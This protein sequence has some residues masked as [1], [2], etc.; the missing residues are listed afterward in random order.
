MNVR[1]GEITKDEELFKA[2]ETA[3]QLSTDIA[4]NVQD[5]MYATTLNEVETGI[6]KLNEFSNKCW[7]LSAITIYTLIYN[8]NMYEQSGLV[9]SEYLAESKS[10]LGLDPRDISEQLSSA[11][12]FI[13]HR[14]ALVRNG[15]TPIGSSRKL[16]R[17]E[18]ALELCGDIDLVINHVINDSWRD[19]KAWYESY[20]KAPVLP[21]PTDVEKSVIRYESNKVYINDI[22]AVTISSQLPVADRERYENY[23]RQV[24]DAI[25]EGLE[26]AIIPCYDYKEKKHLERL[27]DKERAK[28]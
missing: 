11:R 19:F 15:W 13:S 14:E 5:L 25:K 7:L 23:I 21:P 3:I 1:L 6:K 18:L 26:P 17:A 10:R 28:N 27:R 22:E 8:Q 12:F 16:A 20:K 4:P 2:R 24:F 9:W